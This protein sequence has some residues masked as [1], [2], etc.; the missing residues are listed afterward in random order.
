MDANKINYENVI[1][2]SF[3]IDTRVYQQYFLCLTWHFLIAKKPYRTSFQPVPIFNNNIWEAPAVSRVVAYSATLWQMIQQ[4]RFEQL[5]TFSSHSISFKTLYEA[6][7]WQKNI[8]SEDS[9]IFW[10]CLLFYNGDY[11]VTPIFYPVSM[12]ANLAPSFWQTAINVYKQQRRWAWGVENVAYLFFGFL[13]NK[14]ISLR[15]KIGVMLNQIEGFWS[16]ATNALLIFMLGWFP[17]FL[18]GQ[19]FNTTVLS[20]NLPRATSNIMTLTLLSLIVL[21]I[22]STTLLP[23]RPAGKSRFNYLFLIIQWFLI[24]VVVLVFGA[25]PAL[26]AQIRLMLGKYMGFWNTPK[27]RKKI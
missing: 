26:D 10:N 27:Y 18:G 12:D 5:V 16:W 17:L 24:P 14:K 4:V 25:I 15:K 7:Y 19:K 21:M 9:R 8:V 22:V 13:K 23:P 20:Y 11:N 2:S 6:G 3:D 1:V